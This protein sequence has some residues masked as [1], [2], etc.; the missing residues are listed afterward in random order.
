MTNDSA[1]EVSKYICRCSESQNRPF[2]D[3]AHKT[4]TEAQKETIRSRAAAF[5]AEQAA[6]AAAASA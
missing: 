6:K 4:M 5:K 3:G 2:C 1:E